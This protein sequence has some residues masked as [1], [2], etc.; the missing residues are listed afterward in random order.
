MIH[1]FSDPRRIVQIYKLNHRIRSLLFCCND[2]RLILIRL[3]IGFMLNFFLHVQGRVLRM[4]FLDFFIL[5]NL[6]TLLFV[7]P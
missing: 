3:R 1:Y 7:R 6:L 4:L 2:D 5:L